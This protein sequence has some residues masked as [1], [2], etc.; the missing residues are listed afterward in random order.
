MSARVAVSCG[1]PEQAQRYA[2]ALQAVGLE[3]E[4][5]APPEERPLADLGVNGLLLSGGT[6][7]DPALYQQE[8]APESDEPDRARDAMEKRLLE[9]ALHEDLP[10]LAIC[11]GM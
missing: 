9:E 7:V 1:K 4:I 11:R 2:D 8:R 5:L 3:T 10:V 6:D